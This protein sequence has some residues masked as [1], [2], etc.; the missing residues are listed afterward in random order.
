MSD[1]DWVLPTDEDVA[2]IVCILVQDERTARRP[3]GENAWV[4]ASR[5]EATDRWPQPADQSRPTWSIS[6]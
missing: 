1:L 2:A 5:T 6:Q 3:V 4:A